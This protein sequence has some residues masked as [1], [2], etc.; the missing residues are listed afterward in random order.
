MKTVLIA[1]R[2]L[3][4]ATGFVLLWGWVALDVRRFDGAFGFVL[5]AW[6]KILGIT[7]TVIGGSLALICLGFFVVRGRGTAAPFDAPREFVA[8]GPY[9]YVRNPMYIGGV[10]TLFGFGL[11][12]GSPSI[13]LLVVVAF[14]IAQLFVLFVEEPSLQH[15][16]RSAYLEYK[17]SVNRWI[18]KWK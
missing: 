17:K 15:R 8:V 16:F 9:R 13:L 10:T 14:V 11:Y 3:I 6:T 12:Q 18:P 2:T 5:P 4:Y 1:L 7:L